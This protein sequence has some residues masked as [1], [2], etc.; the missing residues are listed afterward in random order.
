MPLKYK[1]SVFILLTLTLTI[2]QNFVT[3]PV[4]L[5]LTVES[6]TL[7]AQIS[8][9]VEYRRGVL[10]NIDKEAE[11]AGVNTI[12]GPGAF[13]RTGANL[14]GEAL[15]LNI[16]ANADMFIYDSKK[17]FPNRLAANP[18]NTFVKESLRVVRDRQPSIDKMPNIVQIS[19]TPYAAPQD[20]LNLSFK[21]PINGSGESFGNVYA[22][23]KGSSPGQQHV[24]QAIV[25]FVEGY[26]SA[27]DPLAG[28]IWVG[29][30]E[31]SH[32]LGF[33]EERSIQLPDGTFTDCYNLAPDEDDHG[34]RH[35]ERLECKK[36]NILRYIEYWNPIAT[37]LRNSSVRANGIKL[38]A[39]QLNTVD[40]DLYLWS[41]EKIVEKNMP[42][43]YFTIQRY[44]S[45]NDLMRLARG[46]Y[47]FFQT[48]DAYRHVKILF[49]RCSFE[50]MDSN[51]ERVDFFTKASGMIRYLKYERELMDYADMM[52]GYLVATAGFTTPGSL[53][54]QVMNWLQ[55]APPSLREVKANFSGSGVESFALVRVQGA[56]RAY[57][58]VWNSSTER[59]DKVTLKLNPLFYGKSARLLRGAGTAIVQEPD[60]PVSSAGAITISNLE[61]DTFV[62]VSVE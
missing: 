36:I 54:P 55:N 51:A 12:A 62:L 59:K 39:L 53:L 58:A 37:R 7:D 22:L 9:K 16:D 11:G 57:V 4:E 61:P 52:Y 34:I 28:N 2:F 31:P 14:M 41:A 6:E 42:I 35:A 60:L 27:L 43:D 44:G 19:G 24:Q 8:K 48:K 25:S 13:Q 32:T 46:A 50:S 10:A 45:S 3:A 49:N 30:Q 33:S 40:R 38:G 21:S 15:D 47:D 20:W 29:T 26:E 17:P 5:I 18:A 1:I 56:K 23:P